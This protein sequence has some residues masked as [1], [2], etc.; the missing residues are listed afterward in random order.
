M[1]IL[2]YKEDEAVESVKEN[3]KSG[4]DISIPIIQR[5]YTLGYNSAGRVFDRLVNEGI[6]KKPSGKFG[7]GVSNIN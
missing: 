3:F 5:R 2:K 1:D 4:E 7:F 6:I